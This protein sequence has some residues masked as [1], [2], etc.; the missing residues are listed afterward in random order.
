MEDHQG[1]LA[2]CPV[3]VLPE[4]AGDHQVEGILGEIDATR[5]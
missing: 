1:V 5:T 2:L 4:S 3:D